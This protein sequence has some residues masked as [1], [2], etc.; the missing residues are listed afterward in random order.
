MVFSRQRAPIE[1]S[2]TIDGNVILPSSSTKLLGV[3]L[4]QSLKWR[5]H[6]AER[7]L[8]FKRTLHAVRRYVGRTWGL[9]HHR[10][11]TVYAAI[12]EPSLLYAC[13][14]W[15]SFLEAKR[16]VRKLPSIERNFTVLATKSFRTA[17]TSALSVFS[18][19]VPI[20][21]RV[22]ELVLRRMNISRIP[23]FSPSAAKQ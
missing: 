10:L 14:V 5:E 20:D 8:K 13:S 15:A 4:D 11:K 23:V 19:S 9:S 17:D 2:V 7:E 1:V 18:G 3:V 22:K 21:Y 16:G 12:L 6:V